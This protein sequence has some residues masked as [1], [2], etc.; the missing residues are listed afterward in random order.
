MKGE[1]MPKESKE[2]KFLPLTVGIETLGGISTPLAMRGTP[3]PTKRACTFSTASD[4]QEIVT[5]RILVGESQLANKNMELA[6]ADLRGIEPMEKGKPQISVSFDIDRDFS[7]KVTAVEKLSKQQ[8]TVETTNAS[9]TLTNEKIEELLKQAKNDSEADVV[10]VRK[11]ENDTHANEMI[12]QAEK[13]LRTRQESDSMNES[14][15]RVEQTLADLGLLLEAGDS[16]GMKQ[17]ADELQKLLEAAQQSTYTDLFG[18]FG[19]GDNLFDSIFKTPATAQTTAK[20]SP[21]QAAPIEPKSGNVTQ[22]KTAS[23]KKVEEGS[24]GHQSLETIGKVFGGASFSLDP[25]L[26]FVLMPFAENLKAVY[27]DHIKPTVSSVGLSCFRADD[28]FGTR[29]VV[30]EIWERINRARVIIADLTGRNANVFYEVG[31]AHALGKDV[32]LVSQ[33]MDDVPFDLKAL[34]CIVYEFTPRG[35]KEMESKLRQTIEQLMK[36]S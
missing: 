12:Y 33:T 13:Y 3:L 21:Q 35:M 36:S 29:Q 1:S 32:I 5:I 22:S 18:M 8:M 30:F 9:E 20:Q 19:K 15:R 14:D 34:R 10:E 28:V 31:L 11:I 17:K 7:V 23:G 26:C 24:K 25:N 27:V 2:Y 16:D 4:N 6:R